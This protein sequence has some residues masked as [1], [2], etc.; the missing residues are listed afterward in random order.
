MTKHGS[1]IIPRIKFPETEKIIIGAMTRHIHK[2]LDGKMAFIALLMG[3]DIRSFR[4]AAVGKS[5]KSSTPIGKTM[6]KK[7]VKSKQKGS[8][9]S[10]L[11]EMKDG[12]ISLSKK[13][14]N[15]LLTRTSCT[16]ADLAA[17]DDASQDF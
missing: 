12:R 5:S 14:K 15:A 13:L 3:K 4:L 11:S 7:G 8:S 16:E 10:T 9:G 17:L 6:L 2:C 1:S